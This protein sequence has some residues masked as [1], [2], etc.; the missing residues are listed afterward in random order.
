MLLIFYGADS[1]KRVNHENI[2]DC[3]KCKI[4]SFQSG[5]LLSE[6]LCGEAWDSDGT[7]RIYD[8]SPTGRY[9]GGY[10]SKKTGC[11]C[12]FLLYLESGIR[13]GIDCG[14]AQDIAGYGNLGRRAGSLL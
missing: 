4:Y 2:T 12:F 5:G 10:I 14:S 9:P 7:C 1:K 13:Q 6:K 3:S 11:G 8:Q